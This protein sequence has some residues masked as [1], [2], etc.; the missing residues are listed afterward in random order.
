MPGNGHGRNAVG[1]ELTGAEHHTHR[2]RKAAN[3]SRFRYIGNLLEVLLHFGCDRAKLVAVVMLAPQ[4]QSKDRDVI[5]GAGLDERLRDS[6]GHAIEG[7]VELAIDLD[8]CIF[9]WRPD[10]KTNDYQAL[11]GARCGVDIFNTGDL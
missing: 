7:R 3:N 2:S 9:L 4:C 1:I 5:D 8:E 10:Q 11:P 6:R